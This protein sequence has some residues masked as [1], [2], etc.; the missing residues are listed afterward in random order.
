[1]PRPP[2]AEAELRVEVRPPWPFRLRGGSA[3]GLLRRRGPGLQRLLHRDGAPVHVAVVQLA[4]DRVLFAARARSETDAMWG[5]RRLRFAT[6]VDDDLRPFH[7]AHRDDPVIGR[8]L[9]A[10]PALRV[11]RPPLPW[12]ALAAAITRAA[13]RVRARGRHP[14]PADRRARAAAARQ[15][16]LRDA[17]PPAGVAAAAPARLA[18]FDLA[19]SARAH[20]A[21]R[22]RRGRR[23]AASTC[24]PTT[25]MPGW[26]RLRAIPGIGPWTLEIARAATARAT[27]TASRPATSATSSSSAACAPATRGRAPTEAEVREFFAPYGAWKGL[28]GE[29]LRLAA[30]SGL[31]QSWRPGSSPSPGR[32]SF[33][34]ARAPGSRPRD[35]L[36]LAHPGGVGVPLVRVLPA[37]RLG[38]V[39]GEEDRQGG[40]DHGRLQAA[41]QP[42]SAASSPS[43]PTSGPRAQQLVPARGGLQEAP[44]A[45]GARLVEVLAPRDEDELGVGRHAQVLHPQDHRRGRPGAASC[46]AL[47]VPERAERRVDAAASAW[48][49]RG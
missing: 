7:E 27:T 9:R 32:N 47:V 19:P 48:P 8:A 25:R 4:P 12:E 1:M 23:R 34:I 43:S 38:V 14:A 31:P 16:G 5:I 13:D 11:R 15:T 42:G 3:D 24:S 41:V 45:R 2:A 22:G 29:Y 49:A 20:A 26:R 21:P 44:D 18:A 17:P 35:Q 6:G 46:I 33:V 10:H 36:V 39:R 40:L 28:A 37:E 30:A